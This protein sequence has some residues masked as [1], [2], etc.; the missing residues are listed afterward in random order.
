MFLRDMLKTT[1]VGVTKSPKVPWGGD[2]HTMKLAG[3]EP[4]KMQL[5]RTP[6]NHNCPAP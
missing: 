4:L 6:A 1:T 3:S 5:G 2:L